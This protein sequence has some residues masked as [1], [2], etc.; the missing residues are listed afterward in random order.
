MFKNW[1][2][3]IFKRLV[4]FLLANFEI[5]ILM[6]GSS[7]QVSVHHAKG[8]RTQRWTLFSLVGNLMRDSK[9]FLLS[10]MRQARDFRIYKWTLFSLVGSL[11]WD[12]WIRYTML[13]KIYLNRVWAAIG[14]DLCIFIFII[15]PIRANDNRKVVLNV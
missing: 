5:R 14:K 3:V 2:Q 15:R 6:L 9:L 4:F 11:T 13:T 8:V 10:Q 12:S 7:I 1:F